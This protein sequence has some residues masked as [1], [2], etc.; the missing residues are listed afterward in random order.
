M[1]RD[2]RLSLLLLGALCLPGVDHAS[3]MPPDRIERVDAY[4]A[5][6]RLEGAADRQRFLVVATSVD[7]VTEDVTEKVSATLSDPKLA[8]LERNVLLPVS[9]GQLQLNLEYGGKKGVLADQGVR[10][11][12][13]PIGELRDGRHARLH[14]C[15]LQYGR[16]PRRRPRQGRFSAFAVRLRSRGRPST[17]HT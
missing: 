11:R 6:V 9:D 1:V 15:R 12:E 2:Y 16:L 8:R 10:R 3:A 7:G 5:D 4:P 14:P 13:A 17:D